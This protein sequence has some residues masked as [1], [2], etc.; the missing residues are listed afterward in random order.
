MKQAIIYIRVSTPGQAKRDHDPEGYSIPAQRD[1]CTNKAKALDAAVVAEF[2]DAGE[3][4]RSVDRTKLQA[5]LTYL[6]EAKGV[7]YVIV[8]KVD[9]LARSREDD[10]AISL[11]INKA[12]ATLV[13]VTENIDETPSGRLVHGIMASIAD[14]YSGNLSLEVV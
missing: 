3:S 9:R 5:M 4:A 6:K 14:F 12:G 13:S 10:V 1:A 7:D 11:A 8:H 2:V